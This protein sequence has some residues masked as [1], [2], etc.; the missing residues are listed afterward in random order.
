MAEEPGGDQEAAKQVAEE[1]KRPVQ[2][3]G[4]VP[5]EAGKSRV[6]PETLAYLTEVSAH[7]ETLEDAEERELLLNNVLEELEGKELRVAADAACSRLLETLLAP[8]APRH[9]IAFMGA[10]ADEDA[11]YKLAGR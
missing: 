1:R 6:E 8:A 4:S 10:F 9:L 3:F 5:W 7:L 11:M 2:T